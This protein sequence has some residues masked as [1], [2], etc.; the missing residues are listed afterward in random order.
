MHSEKPWSSNWK[1]AQLMKKQ[2]EWRTCEA[3]PL[4]KERENVV[5][6]TGNPDADIL[7]VSGPPSAEED[8][9]GIPMD[10]AAGA[11]FKTVWTDVLGR[12]PDELY[13]T[14]ILGCTIE[15]GRDPSAKEKQACLPRLEDII[16]LVDPLLIIALGGVA[17]NALVSGRKWSVLETNGGLFSS[18]HPSMQITS[19]RGGMDI[20]GKV[21]PLK[22][23]DKSKTELGYDVLA[24]I[25]PSYVLRTD[26][27]FESTGVFQDGGPAYKMID[28]LQTGLELVEELKDKYHQ[29]QR[30]LERLD[31]GEQH[32]D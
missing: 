29:T 2:L 7:V 9:S 15:S 13:F 30:A 25:H 22:G 18:P 14:N 11:L 5:F 6:G 31:I 17:L 1:S 21:L 28:A 4:H 3:C 8:E 32:E 23:D 27:N 10:G 24:A 16:Y 19:D 12:N 26:P 20:S